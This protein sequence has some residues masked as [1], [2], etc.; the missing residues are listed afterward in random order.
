MTRHSIM[1]MKPRKRQHDLERWFID[2]ETWRLNA[3]N[4]AFCVIK[5]WE[6]DIT[7]VFYSA[8]E[9]KDF[10]HSRPT[11]IIVYAH[12]C[13]KFDGLA[14]YDLEEL[15]PAKRLVA[16]NRIVSMT[17]DI[18]GGWIT[19]DDYIPTRTIEWRDTVA[20]MPLSIS[21]L[22]DSLGL[23][24]GET[25]IDYIK[26]NK[27]E[28][29]PLDVE[30]CVRDV[31][32]L[33][34][35]IIQLDNS[36]N[37]WCKS[38]PNT[39][40]LPPTAASMAYRI[41]C[42]NYWPEQWVSYTKRRSRAKGKEGQVLLDE[43]GNPKTNRVERAFCDVRANQTAKEAYF[44][45][46]VQVIGEP[47]LLYQDVHSIDA[48]SLYP[49]V[50]LNP[51]PN[52][53]STRQVAPTLRNLHAI[54]E[55]ETRLCWADITLVAGPDSPTFLP[56]TDE[57]G[58][59]QWDSPIFEGWLCEPEIK[60]ALEN[61][62]SIHSIRGL[63]RAY[64]L[65]PFDEYVNH[66]YN[67]RKEYQ[68][69][70]DAREVFVKILLNALYGRF[71]MKDICERVD[72]PD[73]LHEMLEGDEWLDTH[74]LNFY[75]GPTGH[76]PYLV[77]KEPSKRSNS[78]WFGFAAF[79]TSYGRVAL[80]KVI[81]AAG[82]NAIYCDTDSVHFTQA[83]YDDV[84]SSISIGN[85]LGMWKIETPKAGIPFARYW[86]PK[87][88]VHFDGNHQRTKVK[89]KGVSVYD[90]EGNFKP[91]AG[92]LTKPQTYLSV[93]QFY[94]ALRR[95]TLELGEELLMTKRSRRWMKDEEGE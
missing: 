88:Y 12:N 33:R 64:T 57:S 60:Y 67:L 53:A 8:T 54:L 51:Y 38:P 18:E 78:T 19:S 71:G 55:D 2:I 73:R 15:M 3:R 17:I 39:Y 20:L 26:G 14:F 24:K 58:R 68:A 80:Q 70:N 29:T 85:D 69:K 32:I 81:Q 30:Y 40:E 56:N 10:L 4:F 50:M 21:K 35:G 89:H 59:R 72:Q 45:G 61:G 90:D 28:I 42:M 6:G 37:E 82:E 47:A 5:N 7:K 13:W 77:E 23:P 74:E 25:P 11:D 22:G 34:R 66:F 44:G 84:M 94:T 86:E 83:G 46:R 87:C 76:W 91:E 95:Q 52:M 16:G 79:T 63:W 93:V 92:D 48:N 27:R 75:D 31:E 36:F 62:Y 1:R 49:S 43:K 41:W 65:R 9:A